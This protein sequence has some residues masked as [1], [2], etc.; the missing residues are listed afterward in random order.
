[1]RMVS[2]ALLGAVLALL[3][4]ATPVHAGKKLPVDIQTDIN[5]RFPAA[6]VLSFTEEPQK[7]F[8]VQLQLKGGTK[9]EV[10]Y[11][12]KV[13]VKHVFAAE[14]IVV[15][16][17]PV[18]V[19]NAVEKKFPGALV[20]KAEKVLNAKNQIILFQVLITVKG[21]STELHVTPAGAIVN[22]FAVIG[23]APLAPS[24]REFSVVRARRVEQLPLS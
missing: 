6:K 7:H 8:E 3:C 9:I 23:Q 12:S 16:D 24:Y 22:E 18:A 19:T 14:E 5:K 2:C 17:L 20:K 10:I 13:T 15:K 1:M 4:V 11:K 21:K